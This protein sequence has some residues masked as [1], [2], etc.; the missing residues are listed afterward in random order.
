MEGLFFGVCCQKR[1]ALP[2]KGW[3]LD[4]GFRR[5][6][7]PQMRVSGAESPVFGGSA[8]AGP[9]RQ[10]PDTLLP[11][12]DRCGWAIIRFEKPG[13]GASR[14]TFLSRPRS[15]PCRSR[16]P[17]SQSGTDAP[18]AR[19]EG[20]RDVAAVPSR[21]A[22]QTPGVGADETVKASAF[23]D[24]FPLFLTAVSVSGSDRS[25][26]R[27]RTFG[28]WA[29]SQ[30][31]TRHL[32]PEAALNDG[33]TRLPEQCC[34]PIIPVCRFCR[35]CS[36]KA[37]APNSF[38]TRLKSCPSVIRLNSPRRFSSPR[39]GKRSI[40]AHRLT[41]PKGCPRS[42]ALWRIQGAPAL[43]FPRCR[44][45]ASSCSQRSNRRLGRDFVRHR[46]LSEQ[47]R[48]TAATELYPKCRLPSLVRGDPLRV[49]H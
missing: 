49:S 3:N 22:R 47:S 43:I 17:A 34:A 12:H 5:L 15:E 31:P 9:V 2:K 27:S 37:A 25:P 38:I 24:D 23:A 6:R 18:E 11:C 29:A 46:S 21:M 19:A 33:K 28:T 35:Q 30:E 16:T 48:Q 41:V 40:P 4:F 1:F 39:I 45:I 42:A 26:P 13:S 32:H 7:K 10:I 44:S 36:L 20:G 14:C 8:P